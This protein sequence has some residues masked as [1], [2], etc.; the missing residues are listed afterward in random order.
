MQFDF[1]LG[2][3]KTINSKT[4]LL[5]ALGLFWQ[6]I[7]KTVLFVL[8][9]L[10]ILL[11]AFFWQKSLSGGGWSAEKKQEYLNTQNKGVTFR[12]NDFK[13]VLADIELRKQDAT[14]NQ[15]ER[16]DIFKSY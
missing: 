15:M 14:T 13:K 3:N 9:G 11:G 12:E 10:A 2:K 4:Q 5:P 6:K 8:L 16:R 7:Y 1:K